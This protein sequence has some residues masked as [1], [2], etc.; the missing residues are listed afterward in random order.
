MMV[1]AEAVIGR[2]REKSES[3]KPKGLFHQP[4]DVRDGGHLV[5]NG[6]LVGEQTGVAVGVG[7]VVAV[8]GADGPLAHVAGH[9]EHALFHQ[10][11]QFA[12]VAVFEERA[13]PAEFV[14]GH[15]AALGDLLEFGRD[16]LARLVVEE[17]EAGHGAV[18]DHGVIAL[19]A[20]GSASMRALRSSNSSQLA[21]PWSLKTYSRDLA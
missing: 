10:E 16:E 9:D 19:H 2:E 12:E 13:H 8:H 20:T 11:D 7:R 6:R 4:A 3:R 18:I 15:D 21:M 1:W 5:G 14:V 17:P